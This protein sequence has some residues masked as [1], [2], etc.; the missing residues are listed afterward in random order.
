MNAIYYRKNWT[1][2]QVR[3]NEVRPITQNQLVKQL[4]HSNCSKGWIGQKGV[5]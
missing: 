1:R 2:S 5:S 4:R 3:L